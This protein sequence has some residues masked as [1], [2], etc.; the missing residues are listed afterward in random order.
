LKLTHKRQWELVEF[1]IFNAQNY[2]K[3]DWKLG[4]VH[5]SLE[6]KPSEFV[7]HTECDSECPKKYII[8]LVIEVIYNSQSVYY[9]PNIFE[10][11]VDT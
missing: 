2:E 8:Y 11:R 6:H 4:T 1:N 9:L 5:F 10:L 7:E 3:N